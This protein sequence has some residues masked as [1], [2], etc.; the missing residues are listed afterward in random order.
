MASGLPLSHQNQRLNEL[1]RKMEIENVT[2][3]FIE[4]RFNGGIHR[5]RRTDHTGIAD[6]S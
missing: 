3:I 1:N 5:L 6:A 4:R 2:R